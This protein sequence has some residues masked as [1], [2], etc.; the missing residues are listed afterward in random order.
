MPFSVTN[1]NRQ[2]SPPGLMLLQR[3][4]GLLS[5][6]PTIT[7]AEIGALLLLLGLSVSIGGVIERS[8]LMEAFPQA[9]DSAWSAM[10]LMVVILVI[11]YPAIAIRSSQSHYRRNRLFGGLHAYAKERQTCQYPV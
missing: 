8:H 1:C 2:R 10:L 5:Q 9:F 3:P 4:A 7:T 11:G 6:R